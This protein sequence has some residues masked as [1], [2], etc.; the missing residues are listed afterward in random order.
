MRPPYE[1][2]F[3]HFV[4]IF[5]SVG[6][7]QYVEST[8]VHLREVLGV[9]ALYAK[10]NCIPVPFYTKI[11]MS[12]SERSVRIYRFFSRFSCRNWVSFDQFEVHLISKICGQYTPWPA[13][14]TWNHSKYWKCLHLIMKSLP[15]ANANC[16]RVLSSHYFAAEHE[17]LPEDLIDLQR[18][19]CRY[20]F[21]N[22]G[23]GKGFHFGK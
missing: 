18:L 3:V 1:I 20:N 14:I 11:S 22:S 4:S 23:A 2:L 10:I 17:N 15:S 8:D 5:H 9:P 21:Q 12:P 19:N 16:V 7:C 6:F 13:K